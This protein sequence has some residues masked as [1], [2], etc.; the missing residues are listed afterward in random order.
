MRL[1]LI[2]VAAILMVAGCTPSNQELTTLAQKRFSTMQA[3]DL[4]A[5]GALYTDSAKVESTGFDKPAVGGKGVQES[6]RRYFTSSPDLNC[7]L[8]RM[9]VGTDA[10]VLEYSSSG[11]MTQSELEVAIPD[12]F[13]GKPYTLHHATRITVQDGKITSEMTWFDQV[14]FLRQMG[15]FDQH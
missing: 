2:A 10:V 15:F 4:E 7:T 13:R 11:T 1:P 8:E 6:Y 3:H 14:A 5:L 9:T 12:Y